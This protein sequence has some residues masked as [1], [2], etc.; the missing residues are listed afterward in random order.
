MFGASPAVLVVFL[1]FGYITMILLAAAG[2]LMP[3]DRER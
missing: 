2:W 3:R 1:A